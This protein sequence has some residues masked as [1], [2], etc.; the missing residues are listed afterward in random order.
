M[1]TKTSKT[2]IPTAPREPHHEQHRQDVE[3]LHEQYRRKEVD[4]HQITATLEQMVRAGN[5]WALHAMREMRASCG[6]ALKQLRADYGDRAA[7][8]ALR[9]IKA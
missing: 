3:A 5:P 7:A 1:A 4:V 6:T 9:C 8:E 2:S